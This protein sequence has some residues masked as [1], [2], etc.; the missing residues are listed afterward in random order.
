MK[1]PQA[2]PT[3]KELFDEAWSKGRAD[4]VLTEGRLIPPARR[5]RHWD[6]L[7]RLKPPPGFDHREWW[8]AIKL[9]RSADCR[10]IELHDT[11]G[12]PFVFSMAD[13]IV[14]YLHEIDRGTAS[15]SATADPIGNPGLSDRYVVHSLIEE[16]ITSSQ[17]E[18]AATTRRVAK[19]MIRSGRPPRDQSE[20]MILNNY[21]A[22]QELG[23]LAKNP[24]TPA[25]LFH[26]HKIVTSGTLEDSADAGRFRSDER[27]IDVG[28]PH[29]STK[30]F[31]RPPRAGQLEERVGAMCAFANGESPK[32]FVHPVVRSIILHF[33]LAYDHP[34]V[35]GNGRTARTL[36]YWSMRRHRYWICEF[37]SISEIIRK[38]PARYGR[39]FLYTETDDNDLTYFILYHLGLI[40]RAIRALKEYVERKTKELQ[41]LERK[42]RAVSLLNHREQA[43]ISHALRHPEHRY[44]IESHQRSHAVVYQTARADL[45]D[46]AKRGL[47]RSWKVGREWQFQAVDDLEERLRD[48]A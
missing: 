12:K 20:L 34:F 11:N 32:R 16:A 25:V 24:L 23:G 6:K 38:A 45:L 13:P 35:D 27:T 42:M 41:F 40:R 36:F 26:L 39:A 4:K 31:H 18:G 46:L 29:D 2:P 37:I 44:T 7:R 9:K 33:W 30:V 21:L 15:L 10:P 14:E 5:Y 28:D 22:M 19:E 48:S 47:F 17:L 3:L 8:L 43:I 1:I